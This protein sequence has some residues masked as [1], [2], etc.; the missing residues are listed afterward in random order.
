MTRRKIAE[1][2]VRVVLLIAA[3]LLVRRQL[4]TRAD[5]IATNERELAAIAKAESG[6]ATAPHHLKDYRQKVVEAMREDLRALVRGESLFTADSGHPTA[7]LPPPYWPQVTMGN[8]F[9]AIR[10]TPQGWHASINNGITSTMCAVAV[11]PDTV[12]D[13]APSGEPVC[14][15][16]PQQFDF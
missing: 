5:V 15:S 16:Q 4:A 10:V 6:P 13:D 1:Y 11:G 14:R 3:I 12:L 7:F 2:A 9:N 8:T